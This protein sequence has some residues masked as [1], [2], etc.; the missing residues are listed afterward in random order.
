M[1]CMVRVFLWWISPTLLL[2][3]VTYIIVISAH[4]YYFAIPYGDPQPSRAVY[5]K[6]FFYKVLF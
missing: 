1:A 4:I 5:N 3:N 2:N 6:L